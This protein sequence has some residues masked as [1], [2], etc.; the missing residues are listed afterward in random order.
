VVAVL[1]FGSLGSGPEDATFAEGMQA[2]IITQLTRL[3]GLRV[4]AQRSTA[5]YPPGERDL[6]AIARALGADALL[7]GTVQR[8]GDRAR[9][10]VQLVDPQRATQLWAERYDRRVADVFG[11]QTEVAVEIAR[12]LGARLSP[13]ERAALERPSTRDPEA[14]ELLRRGLYFWKRSIGVDSDNASAEELIGR[15]AAR[16][17]SFAEAHAWLATIAVEWRGDCPAAR[18]HLERAEALAPD[19]AEV[20][21]AAGR[22]R[23]Q[24][25]GDARAA[26]RE[27]EQAVLEAPGDAE[28]RSLLGATRTA[29]GDQEGLEDLRVAFQL[30]PRS[31]YAAAELARELALVR[32]FDEAARA[33]ARAQELAPGDVHA[34]I[35]AALIP[36]WRDGDL[37][38]ARRALAALPAELPRSG[39]GA[40]S[41]FQLLAL[42]PEEAAR[43][44]EAGRVADPFSTG[45]FIPRDYVAGQAL[46]ELGRAEPARAA[47][48]RV[49]PALERRLASAPDDVLTMLF[50]ARARVGAGQPRLAEQ[51]VS[52]ALSLAAQPWQRTSALRFAAEIDAAAGRRQEAVASLLQVLARP[53]GLLTA[54]AVRADPRFAPLR[55]EPRLQAMTRGHQPER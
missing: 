37:A 27:Y 25:D 1:P 36:F 3:A 52:R 31:Y 20:H 22:L 7:E 48:A 39:N 44:L 11:V 46:W 28:A 17:P 21:L 32:R 23:D 4:I 45:P 38:P 19:R 8:Q 40:W 12:A 15:A 6:G 2:E 18:V 41:L 29:I 51:L 54:A 34:M 5:A 10:T 55:G 14:A 24:C 13:A 53:D 47:F 42:L 33:C 30:D 49:V 26:I 50:L 16:D 9:L 35:L 43:L